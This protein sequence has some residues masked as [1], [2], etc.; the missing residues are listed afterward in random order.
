MKLLMFI[1]ASCFSV[2]AMA[3]NIKSGVVI[4]SQNAKSLS[5]F[6]LVKVR[7][8]DRAYAGSFAVDGLNFSGTYWSKYEALNITVRA[9]DEDGQLGQ[10]ILTIESKL[11][12]GDFLRVKSKLPD[13]SG[14]LDMYC[15][16][17]SS[18]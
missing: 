11:S 13:G 15:H 18:R 5:G 10:V 9:L 1:L 4:C 12:S 2:S 6:E 7:S 3:D 16:F 8:K 17:V 14:D